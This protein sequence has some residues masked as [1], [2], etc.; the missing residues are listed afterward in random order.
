MHRKRRTGALS[1]FTNM[2]FLERL[3]RPLG[4]Q[5]IGVLGRDTPLD[6]TSLELARGSL[7]IRE[8]FSKY[9]D[10]TPSP[11]K[12][13]E[14]WKRFHAAETLCRESN[15]RIRRSFS[16]DPFW[17]RVAMRVAGVLGRFSWDECSKFFAFGPGATTRLP[18]ARSFAAY[19]YSGIPESTLGNASLA[20][21]CIRF[22][23]IWEQIVRS[24]G[25]VQ[26]DQLIKVVPGNSIIT[27]PK[28]YKTDRTIAKEPDMN[29]YVQKGIGRVIRNR[30]KS[31]GV[32]LNDQTRNQRGA[33]LGSL[34]G[35]LATVDLSMASDTVAFELVSFLLPN[36]WWWALEQ[37]RSP[38]GA[39][40]SGELI[41][42]QKFSS[43]GNGYT[44][45]LE[46]LFF[47]CICQE[48]CCRYTNEKDD[49]ILVY[50]DDIVIPTEK[51]PI[52]LEKLAEAGFK[53]NPDKTF[54][55]GP[56]RESCGKHYFN[57]NEITPFY[58]RRPVE[59]LDRLFLLHNNV[60]RW[61]QRTGVDL[62][63]FLREVRLLSPSAWRKPRL[64]DGF[65]DGAF[66]GSV[67]ELRLDSHPYGWEFWQV[68]ALN[69]SSKELQD[70]LPM[71]QL[72]A[73][74]LANTRDISSES[75]KRCG[76]SE[77][78]SGLPIKGGQYKEVSILIPR[79]PTA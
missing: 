70:N 14:T 2:Q 64:P 12:D 4:I 58:V 34:D 78:L 39:L 8:L 60:Y 49:R 42:Y 27:V 6:L 71:G 53:P 21:A 67:D 32:D 23:P 7:L 41:H 3:S 50:G 10:G 47:W 66:I 30:L 25:E 11:E 17:R 55:S 37:A 36:D 38:V 73:S 65:G 45:E 62:T 46:S 31:V 18:R 76:F 35:S 1:G 57:G 26:G 51:S 56:Y 79:Y 72:L 19:K 75:H 9:D 40:A 13:A 48:V 33:L 28:S 43:M 20:T 59:A 24:S 77:S 52:L 74:L 16:N 29:I 54:S 63:D 68:K 15:L 5:P 22:V 61:S 69:V 44:F